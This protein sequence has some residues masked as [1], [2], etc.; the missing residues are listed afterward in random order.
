MHTSFFVLPVL[1]ATT[2]LSS[3]TT[4]RATT[5][6]QKS[7]SPDAA[8]LSVTEAVATS[9]LPKVQVHTFKN[10]PQVSTAYFPKEFNYAEGGWSGASQVQTQPGLFNAEELWTV[11]DRGLNLYLEA[12][13]SRDNLQFKNGDRY[14]PHPNFNQ[15]LFRIKLS[16]TGEGRVLEQI[17]LKA[18]GAPTNGL[19]SA[20]AELSTGEK[21]FEMKSSKGP[22]ARLPLSPRGFDFEGVAQT[23]DK[24]GQREFWL[25]EEYGPSVL[26]ADALGNITQHWK[27]SKDHQ[28]LQNSL[29]WI[30]RHRA[31]NRGFEG[32]T[33]SGAHVIA[34]LQSPLDEK[35]G[36]SGEP[37]H[38]NKNTPLHRLV[39]IHRDTGEVEQFAYNHSENATS[40]GGKHKDV[41][42]GDLAALD[43]SGNRF[44][45]LEHSNARK[46]MV[47]IEAR[48]TPQTTRLQDTN[49]YEAGKTSYT[50]V[51]TKIVADLS[52]L[53]AGLELPEK[54]EGIM[55]LDDKTL[56]VVFDNDHCIEPLLAG[57]SAPKECENLMVTIGFP[58]PLFA[59]K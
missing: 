45:V 54:A 39:R 15:T 19:P 7:P 50:P 6:A 46:H 4:T 29:P 37:G 27:P 24:N 26:R 17:G 58:S 40:T 20:I 57:K 35:G 32:L 10:L 12:K 34:A 49:S 23:F 25:V 21:P 43:E 47:L 48:I 2:Y 55:L 53:L 18:L 41:K 56:V 13:D 22:F 59:S 44:L 14:F 52:P 33:V 36:A 16:S 31:D 11:N 9:S 5:E 28:I 1:A 42:I 30:F 51:E 8:R 3:C 38:G